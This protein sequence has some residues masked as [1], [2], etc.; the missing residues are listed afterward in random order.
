MFGSA[1]LLEH[2][3]G[4]KTLSTEDSLLWSSQLDCAST[5]VGVVAESDS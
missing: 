5:H 4:D 2:S 1:S 3:E